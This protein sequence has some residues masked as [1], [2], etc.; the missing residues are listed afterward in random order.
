MIF[1]I[2]LASHDGASDN[3]SFTLFLTMED[4]GSILSH[5]EKV[6]SL[7]YM[8]NIFSDSGKEIS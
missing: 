4:N 7:A 1:K 3:G 2:S 6:E 5:V 8:T